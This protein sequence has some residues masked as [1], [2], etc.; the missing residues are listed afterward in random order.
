M[1]PCP[2]QQ[3]SHHLRAFRAPGRSSVPAPVLGFLT[4][5]VAVWRQGW[6]HQ[7]DVFLGANHS[8]VRPS[9]LADKASPAHVL[10]VQGRHCGRQGSNASIPACSPPAGSSPWPG[11]RAQS[12]KSVLAPC[13]G[14]VP[15][16]PVRPPAWGPEVCISTGPL[17]PEAGSGVWETADARTGKDTPLLRVTRPSSRVPGR[18]RN[19][20]EKGCVGKCQAWVG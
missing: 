11:L 16:P 5:A 20:W 12:V 18:G 17:S 3:K 7:Q 15:C 13:R 6:A 9:H 14:A 10:L 8:H 19:L 1:G 2:K 4:S